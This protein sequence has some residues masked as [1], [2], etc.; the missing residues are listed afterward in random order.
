M[1]G[2]VNPVIRFVP[3]L[4]EKVW[5]GR[6]LAAYGKHLP[7]DTP[8]GESWELVDRATGSSVVSAPAELAGTTLGE[9][10]DERREEI[11][12][13]AAATWGENFPI[14]VKLLD[15]TQS[16]SV[17]VHP[18]PEVAAELDG[19][20]KT[21][22]WVVVE[23]EPGAHLLAG[24]LPG[25]TRATFGAALEAGVDVSGMVQRLDPTP[26]D[27]LHL[28]AGRVHAIGAGNLVVEV[29]QSSDTTYRVYDFDRPGLD[30]QPR[31]LHIPESLAALDFD[32]V[33]PSFARPEGEVLVRCPY[34]VL[35]RWELGG[36]GPRRA[37]EAG[38]C[39]ILAGLDGTPTVQGE[40]LA[41]GA[42]VLTPA[43]SDC[44]VAGTG[45][46]LRI[47]LPPRS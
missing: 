21:E 4:H 30:G 16:L 1:T 47:T 24:F 10:W 43:T 39:A 14:L 41:V 34:Y 6:R 37:T 12:G 8:I 23:A 17:Q 22:T 9:L 2:G 18:P 28:P 46:V 27:V 38:E 3:E 5:G 40:P 19:E 11:F 45:T 25:V 13:A 44:A 7:D 32:D 42:F 35:E 33:E 20:P 36:G 31:E 26:G 15:C 29:Q